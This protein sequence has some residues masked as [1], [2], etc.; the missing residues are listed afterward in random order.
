MSGKKGSGLRLPAGPKGQ[1]FAAMARTT[2]GVN[3]TVRDIETFIKNRTELTPQEKLAKWRAD[4]LKQGP[5]GSKK[6]G[7]RGDAQEN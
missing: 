4:R 5:V 6:K 1:E 3:A 7:I 2:L